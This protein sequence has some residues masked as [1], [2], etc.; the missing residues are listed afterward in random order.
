MR[1]ITDVVDVGE[2]ECQC[3][4]VDAN[5]SL[6]LTN[7]FIVTHNTF[8][9]SFIIFDEAQ[10][11]TPLQMKMALTRIAEGS[12][13]VV[14]G[15]LAQHDRGLDVNGLGDFIHKIKDKGSDRI[16]TIQFDRYDIQ[17]HPVIQDILS[18]Y[19]DE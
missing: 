8:K 10:D 19:G 3:I 15:D 6:Y 9:K 4:S 7:N 16:A 14:T 2:E 5:D 17:R 11:S 1:F 12:K 13:M 18:A